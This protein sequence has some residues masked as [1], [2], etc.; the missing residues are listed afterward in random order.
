[1]PKVLVTGATGHLGANLVRGLL[2]AGHQVV[3]L[4][5]SAEAAAVDGLDVERRHGDVRDRDSVR[6]AVNGCDQVFH[7]AAKVSILE[8]ARREIFETNVLGTRHVLEAA[9]DA[10]VRRVVVTG[11]F[12][13]IG[14]RPG[15]P[16]DESVPFDP[17][18]KHTA[19]EQTKLLVEHEVFRAAAQGMDV[20]LAT[21]CAIIGP[22]DYKPSRMGRVLIDI[23]RGRFPAFIPGGFE[24]VTTADIVTGHLLAMSR[25]AT[26][27]NYLFGSGYRSMDQLVH[28]FAELTGAKPPLR[29]PRGLMAGIAGVVSPVLGRV[30]PGHEQLIT[31][32]SVRLL[33]QQRRADC[34]KAR[35]ELG[36]QPTSIEQAVREAYEH[37][38]QRGVIPSP[39]RPARPAGTARPDS[40][41]VATSA[42]EEKR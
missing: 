7:C 18:T 13:A 28:Q 36:Y 31:P 21:S 25:G 35:T 3:V 19:Y 24:F 5:H 40:D 1:M 9:R 23:G 37:F 29:L 41:L 12:G 33:A 22:H 11:S 15:G 2:A 30:A 42:K 38:V 10:G 39:R 16:S 6:A 32:A 14:D 4:L 34:A 20:V 26:G 17:F 8:T 27:H